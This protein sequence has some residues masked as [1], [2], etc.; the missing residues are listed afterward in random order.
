MRGTDGTAKCSPSHPLE[1][2]GLWRYCSSFRSE[3]KLYFKL[4]FFSPNIS[5][6]QPVLFVKLSSSLCRGLCS[7][8]LTLGA[9]GRAWS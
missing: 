5:A 7:F 9:S 1:T 6:C 4:G 8:L 2:K 3:A